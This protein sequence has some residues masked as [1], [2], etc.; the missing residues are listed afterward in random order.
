M[1]K[2]W[3]GWNYPG[4]TR[5][6]DLP[7]NIDITDPE[8]IKKYGGYGLDANGDG[9]A[10][11]N[12]PIDAIHATAKY[13]AANHKPGED[14]YSRG[15]AIWQYN[16]DYENY[17]L[18]VKQYAE[19][20]ARPV[21]TVSGSATATG[22]FLWPVS[23]GRISSSYG[24]RFHPI[25]KEYQE[26]DGIDIAKERGAPILASDGG[27]V[28]ESRRS[29]G[30]GWKIVIDHGNGYQT[31]YAHMEEKD[32][33]VRAGQQVKKGQVIALV[34]SNGWSTGPHLHFEVHQNGRLINPL[35]VLKEP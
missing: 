18:K 26:H 1:D 7:D 22:Q 30:Y 5:L 33:K 20:F 15:G 8:L 13:L 21:I 3:V 11:P 12:D 4:G 34:G 16:H 29:S 31:L 2:S 9:K 24:L 19:S 23:G 6:G 17:V 27:V 14:W 32:V 10:D 25:E 35:T 28:T